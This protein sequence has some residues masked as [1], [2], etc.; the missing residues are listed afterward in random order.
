MRALSI[1]QP[2]AWLIVNGIK[3]IEN[4]NWRTDYRGY[5]LIHA[6]KTWDQEG[7]EV[8]QNK[9]A[10]WEKNF[11]PE[12]E[13]CEFGAL[14]GMVNMVDCVEHHPSKWFFGPWGFVFEAPECWQEPIP[15]RGQLKLFEVP[16]KI[17]MDVPIS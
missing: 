17:F 2:W 7:Y 10:D 4:R 9:L 8:I 12:K 6:S 3:D 13:D 11:L 16:N 15:Y 1:R 5:L 14:I